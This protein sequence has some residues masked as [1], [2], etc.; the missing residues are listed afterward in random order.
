MPGI[1]GCFTNQ[2]TRKELIKGKN[3]L[4]NNVPLIEDSIYESRNIICTRVHLGVIGEYTSPQVLNNKKCWLEGEFY[5][6]EQV[7]IAFKLD[8]TTEANIILEAMAK[9]VLREVLQKIDGFFCCVLHDEATKSLIFI[10]DRFGLKPLYLLRRNDEIVAWSSEVK[11]FF[12]F[13][14]FEK[15]INPDNVR[16]FLL[17]GHYLNNTTPFD[18]ISLLGPSSILTVS[19]DT[20]QKTSLENYWRWSMAQPLDIS[21]E[22]ATI[23]LGTLLNSAI[24]S[25]MNNPDKLSVSLSGGLDSRAILAAA[26]IKKQ[27]IK[28]FTFGVHKSYEQKIAQKVA[29]VAQVENYRFD[30]NDKNWF[31]K[32]VEGIWKTD[33][34]LSLIHMHGSYYQESLSKVNPV[35]LHGIGGGILLGGR[36]ISNSKQST[37]Q[38]FYGELSEKIELESSF[39]HLSQQEIPHFIHNRLRRFTLQGVLEQKY[40]EYRMPLFQNDLISFLTSIP[41]KHLMNSRLFNA[42]LLQNFPYLFEGI[43]YSNIGYP[44]NNKRKTFFKIERRLHSLAHQFGLASAYNI[45]DYSKWIKSIY[46]SIKSLLNSKDALYKN[47]ISETDLLNLNYENYITVGRLITIEIYL[48]QIFNQ[49]YLTTEDFIGE[50]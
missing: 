48:Q 22:E 33:G 10:T 28:T 8:E 9:G 3:L 21:F 42:A 2:G 43:P 12:H 29:Q 13:K 16:S 17:C 46:S 44:I 4:L 41:K 6:T 40:I 23:Q 45:T 19:C 35:C 47:Y 34:M 38:S 11:G 24:H 37:V 15:R 27:D 39:F 7:R 18:Q 30:L 1:I 26:K 32:R 5:N 50:K 31:K 14:A 36:L 49:T 20:R 25:R